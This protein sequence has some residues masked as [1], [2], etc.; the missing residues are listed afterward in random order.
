[1]RTQRLTLN[2]VTLQIVEAGDPSRPALL[3]LHGFPDCHRV[4]SHQLEALADDFH[5]IAFDMRGAGASSAPG[6]DR[7]YRIDRLLPD[8]DAVI[9]A[10]RGEQGQVHLVGHDW[11]SIIG[12]SF[13]S[14]PGYGRRVLSWSAMSGPHMGL[15]LD[16]FRAAVTS[17]NPRSVKAGLGQLAHS[18]YVLA[19]NLPGLGRLVFGQAGGP[20]W[21]RVMRQGGVPAGDPYLRQDRAAIRGLTLNTL[22]L[23]QQN[24]FTPPVRPLPAS[25]A[26]PSQLVV[27][28][29]DAFVRPQVFEGLERYVR[30][31]SR[32]SVAANHWAQRQQPERITA[33]IRDFA[34]RHQPDNGHKKTRHQAGSL[35]RETV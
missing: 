24:L 32:V 31:L 11:G 16:W 5:V 8:I 25:I 26:V 20:V 2:D 12:W 19:M 3:F 29:Q 9:T 6:G 27:L 28:E 34:V 14:E 15:A 23:Y 1:M 21:R 30:D 17:G 7:P 35:S 22:K 33:L 18:W 4:W 10:T 13:V